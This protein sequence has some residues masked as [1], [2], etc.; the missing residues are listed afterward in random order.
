MSFEGA[1][2]DKLRPA[3]IVRVHAAGDLALLEVAT[4]PAAA[5]PLRM[6]ATAPDPR[7]SLPAWAMR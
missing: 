6:A 4:A 7:A 5:R 2:K 3:R 1:E